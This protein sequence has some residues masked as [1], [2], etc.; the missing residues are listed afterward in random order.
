MIQRLVG[1]QLLLPTYFIKRVITT[2]EVATLN[3]VPITIVPAISDVAIVPF[4]TQ[5]SRLDAGNWSSANTTQLKDGA[6]LVY[7]SIAGAVL[8][9][10]PPQ[11]ITAIVPNS[12]GSAS[13]SLGSASFGTSLI[14]QMNTGDPTGT[15]SG[16]VLSI[17]FHL[18]PRSF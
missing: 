11:I 13:T 17:F 4:Y 18:W 5:F 3:T 8:T 9:G 12:G 10:N 14:L 2:A 6:P 1:N 15:G 7:A 16:F